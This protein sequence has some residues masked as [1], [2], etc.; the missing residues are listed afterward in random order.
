[1]G[2]G[3]AA[4]AAL[5]DRNRGL[6]RTSQW[7]KK[8]EPK[9]AFPLLTQTHKAAGGRMRFRMRVPG[10]RSRWQET[11]YSHNP[12]LQRISRPEGL[13]E[14]VNEEPDEVLRHGVLPCVAE[15]SRPRHGAVSQQPCWAGT[16]KKALLRGE[17]H[18]AIPWPK[19]S[20]S[21]CASRDPCGL[22]LQRRASRVERLRRRPRST[23]TPATDRSSR[24]PIHDTGRAKPRPWP[25][26][27]GSN[28]G[29]NGC[30]G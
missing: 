21:S 15:L 8:G 28:P 27:P 10:T 18:R 2:A 3:V 4:P 7:W 11:T 1:M 16:S 17:G 12:H 19:G 13:N 29:R 20:F 5:G 23:D 25:A 14:V 9:R 24:R 22:G 26:L 6:E 30:L